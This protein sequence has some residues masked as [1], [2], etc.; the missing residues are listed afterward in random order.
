M[1]LVAI[2]LAYLIGTFPTAQLVAR[3]QGV[4]IRSAGSGNPGASNVM[5]TLGGR[6][7]IFVGAVD[8]AKGAL[9]A[10]AGLAIDGRTGGY[11]LAAAA[12]VGHLYPLWSNFRGGKGVATGAGAFFVL[13][14][15][16]SLVLV[17]AWLIVAKVT[18]KASL[19]S[20]SV[21]AALPFGVLA[22][23]RRWSEFAAA[24]ALSALVVA[25][26]GANIRRL[27]SRSEPS[28]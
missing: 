8:M 1:L 5:R 20:L 16:A 26:H 19:A 4:D 12:V 25:R 18:A 3:S 10:A 9:P 28:L 23:S 2:P 24:A 11:V 17:P 13:A 27:I 21:A 14:P 22:E 15:L 7:G 6:W